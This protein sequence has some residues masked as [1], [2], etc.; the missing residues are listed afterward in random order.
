[1][2]FL[3]FVDIFAMQN[4]NRPFST[5]F[6]VMTSISG[7]VLLLILLL[8]W[9]K[10]LWDLWAK[11][12]SLDSGIKK[13][14]PEWLYRLSS[15]I[16]SKALARHGIYLLSMVILTACTWIHLIDCRDDKLPP[17]PPNMTQ[18]DVSG[19][20]IT[21]PFSP[22][23]SPWSVTECLILT[24]CVCFLFLRIHY[25]LKLIVANVILVFYAWIVFFGIPRMFSVRTIKSALRKI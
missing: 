5:S 25:F 11:D 21:T 14:Y 16:P 8:T 15:N 1:M 13:P 4:M 20:L 23:M 2:V 12:E 19:E 17:L 7:L 24:M 18:Y 6:W 3:I 10:K 9:Y 22:C